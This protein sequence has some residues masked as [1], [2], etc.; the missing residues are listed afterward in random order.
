MTTLVQIDKFASKWFNDQMRRRGFAVEKKFLFWRKRGPLYDMFMPEILSGG[1]NLR[2]RMSIWS[3]WVD[4]PDDGQLGSFPPPYALVGGTLSEDFPARMSSGELFTI[5]TEQQV[6]ASLN[7]ILSLID[8]YALPWF[9]T[10]NSFESYIA[11][12]DARGFQA[13][14]EGKEKV[15]RGIAQAFDREQYL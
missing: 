2:I 12:V 10:V 4:H 13:T 8:K 3:P 11:Y 5:E 15:R 9:P 6:E 7:N 14:R 1:V